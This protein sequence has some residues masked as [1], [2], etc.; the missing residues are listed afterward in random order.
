MHILCAGTVPFPKRVSLAAPRQ[1]FNV[2]VAGCAN[3][4]F[5]AA[6]T[7]IAVQAGSAVG[8]GEAFQALIGSKEGRVTEE[9][10]RTVFVHMA[11]TRGVRTSF[12]KVTQALVV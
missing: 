12:T 2:R 9:V 1:A 3:G 6:R 5:G 10:S 4:S 11:Y 8:M 7:L